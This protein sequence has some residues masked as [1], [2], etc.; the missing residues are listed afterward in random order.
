MTYSTLMIHLELEHSND[1]R[2]QVAGDLAEAFDAKVIGIAA[3]DSSAPPYYADS[4]FAQRLLTQDRIEVNKQLDIA[5]E[6]FHSNLKG[7]AK[8]LEW[9]SALS[10]PTSFVAREARAADLII[11]GANFD[12]SLLDPSRRLNPNALVIE[13]GRPVFIVPSE[14]KW[15][16]SW[17]VL[18]AWKD[19]REA[20]RAVLDGLPLLQKANEV[21][22]IEIVEDSNASAAQSRVNDV[23]SW[24]AQHGVQGRGMVAD[25]K[26]AIQDQLD[27]TA[28]NLGA[29]FIVAG[30]YGHARLTEWVFGGVTRELLTRSTRCSML[31]H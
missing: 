26:E 24:L 1:A 23:V 15:L 29:D 7:R 13:A 27:S 4:A 9:R 5:A 31:S 25:A 22:V 2:L 3:C 12:G 14:A 8:T 11:T 20:R 19:T 6:R 16:K 30:A 28:S 10:A 21:N 18:V 17:N